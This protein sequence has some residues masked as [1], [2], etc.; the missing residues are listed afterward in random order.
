VCPRRGSW[1]GDSDPTSTL[2]PAGARLPA[3]CLAGATASVGTGSPLFAGVTY[4]TG[5]VFP[6]GYT[7]TAA[8]APSCP[9][10]DAGVPPTASSL[11]PVSCSPYGDTTRLVRCSPGLLRRCPG[12]RRSPRYPLPS[13]RPCCTL[14]AA[15]WRSMRRS[16]P[17]KR[18]IWCHVHRAPTSSPANGSGLTSA[19][20]TAL[21]RYKARWVL[22]GFTQRPGVD[23]DETFSPV[24]KP[25]IVRMV[26]SLALTRGWL[27]H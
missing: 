20:L 7:D 11:T 17:A 15:R 6:A 26:L 5:G 18:G 8:E 14:I 24:V 12:T 19:G 21:E 16:L 10:C 13:A 22:R 3:T 4:A 2:C 25:A 23:Y 9:C 27:V 1:T